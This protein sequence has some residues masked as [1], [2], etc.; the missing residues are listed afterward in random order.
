MYS[1]VSSAVTTTFSAASP[2]Q[3]LSPQCVPSLY[4]A[5]LP[6]QQQQAEHEHFKWISVH[7]I[8][9]WDSQRRIHIL[10]SGFVLQNYSADM[11]KPD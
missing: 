4:H 6:M 2:V 3:V 7:M 11:V 5:K 1:S 9:T 10:L 8:I